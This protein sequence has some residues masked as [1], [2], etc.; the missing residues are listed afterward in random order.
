[1]KHIYTKNVAGCELEVSAVRQGTKC[2]CCGKPIA[3]VLGKDFYQTHTTTCSVAYVCKDCITMQP[4]GT[5]IRGRAIIGGKL[6][7]GNY[8]F[9]VEIEANYRD[10]DPDAILLTN[11]YLAAQWGLQPSSD[12]TVG[13][14]FHMTNKVNFHGL[15]DFMQDVSRHVELDADN[16]GHHINISKLSWTAGDMDA[17]RD[18]GPALFNGLMSA[19]R[20]DRDSTEWLFGR[21]FGNWAKDDQYYMHGSWLN[22]DNTYHIEFRLPHFKGA[23]QFFYCANF[24]RDIIDILDK[25]L[26]T[27]ET[28]KTSKAIVKLFDKYVNGKANCQRAERNT[29]WR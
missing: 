16:C 29:V 1:M 5:D 6:T 4:Y 25:W 18:N 10:D 8:R 26:E 12:Y 19:M 20:A 11:C 21:Y 15:K 9:A 17:I 2:K 27:R 7:A 14:E 13:V 3:G 22:L 28:E 23:N 24:C